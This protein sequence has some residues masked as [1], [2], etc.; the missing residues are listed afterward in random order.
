MS[1][2]YV[3]LPSSPDEGRAGEVLESKNVPGGRRGLTGGLD[4]GGSPQICTQQHS[5]SS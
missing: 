5:S 2:H 1:W 3:G 4:V